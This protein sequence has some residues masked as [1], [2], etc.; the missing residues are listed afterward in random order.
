M[1]RLTNKMRELVQKMM[2]IDIH[3]PI[4]GFSL[5]EQ[6]LFEVNIGKRGD[7]LFL[8]YYSK[9]GLKS[10]FQKYRITAKL[11]RLGFN[12]L[13]IDLDTSDPY[14][15]K[16]KIK[17]VIAD[18]I[19]TLVELVIRRDFVKVEMPFE[20]AQNGQMYE[21]LVVEWLKMQN[22]RKKFRRTRP[23]LPGQDF[24]GLGIGSD[25]LELLVMA[26]RRLGLHGIINIPDHYHNAYFYSRMF[27]FG[28]PQEQAIFK[29]LTRDTLLY[30]ISKVAW[31]IENG[32][33]N[34]VLEN[35]T[36][37][38]F[39]SKQ[40]FPLAK[41]WIKLFKSKA[42]KSEVNKYMSNYKFRIRNK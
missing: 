17:N 41:D 4:E 37:K 18:N 8:G 29:A 13:K 10:I 27:K 22:P 19:E 33:V 39:I 12:N 7:N 35:E 23:Q 38:W 16:I 14:K 15:H 9:N 32:K 26:S 36:F 28:N 6:D 21:A 20:C 25:A 34:N 11:N 2:T 30:P 1:I 31:A 5:S 24:P 40:I 3:D 42:Y